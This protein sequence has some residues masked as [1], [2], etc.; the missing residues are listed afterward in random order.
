MSTA[1]TQTQTATFA[2]GCFWGAEH[3]LQKHY[4]PSSENKGILT[5]TVGYTGG[6]TKKNANPGENDETAATGAGT[7]E[8]AEAVKIEFNPTAVSYD[9]L[10]EYRS[11]IFTHSDE[12]NSIAQRVTE[13]VQAKHFTPK[14]QKIV[15]EILPAGEWFDA[16]EYHQHY[17]VKNPNYV[18]PAHRL[19]W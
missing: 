17:S 12:Q 19:F 13:E 7:A 15:T 14:D 6:N 4:G 11:S 10:V 9:E 8:H 16:E 5:T 1:A 2:L 18:C 3:L